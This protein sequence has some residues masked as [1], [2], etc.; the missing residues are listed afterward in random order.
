MEEKTSNLTNTTQSNNFNN[1]R[2]PKTILQTL[3][4]LNA[5]KSIN[6]KQEINK[7]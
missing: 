5:E 2:K 1:F 3:K 6:T 7:E 4:E